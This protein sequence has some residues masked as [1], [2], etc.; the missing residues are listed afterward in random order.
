M[1]NNL[2]DDGHTVT[3]VDAKTSGNIAAELATNTYDQLFLWDLTSASYLNT[4]DI[5]AMTTFFNSRSNVVVD[6]RSYGYHFQRNQA[7][8]VQLLKNVASA[9][10]DRAGGVWIGTDHDPSW[11]NNANPFLFEIGINPVTGSYSQ[12]VNDTDPSSILLDGVIPTELWAQGQSVGAAPLGIQS[13]GLDMRYHFGHSSPEF[14]AIPYITASF[15]TYIAPDED[16]DPEAVPE[17]GTLLLFGTGLAGL[18]LYRRRSI[19]K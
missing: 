6:T 4:T 14:G 9:F 10:E 16:R 1:K 15:G 19:N 18:A 2:E 7:S 17:P 11:T 13:N 5:A 3:I 8:E 12:A